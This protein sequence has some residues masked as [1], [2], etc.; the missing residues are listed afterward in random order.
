VCKTKEAMSRQIY[1]IYVLQHKNVG[2][3]ESFKQ[4]TFIDGLLI[5]RRLYELRSIYSQHE[6]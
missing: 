3:V 6:F 4:L 2:F 5:S 1:D